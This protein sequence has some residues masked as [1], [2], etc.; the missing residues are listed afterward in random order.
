MTL[1]PGKLVTAHY[2]TGKYVGEIV[3]DRGHAYLIKILAVQ[4]HPQQGDLHNPGQTE[5]VFFHQR[6]ALS[7][8]E[9][10]NISKSSVSP[11]E[12]EVPEYKTSLL[13]SVNRLKEKLDKKDNEFNNQAKQQLE[14][15]E[16]SYLKK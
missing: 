8:Y 11:Y 7:H 15:L 16:A 14:A 2:K 12:G 5:N 1:E 10:A 13:E 3:E 9:K 6:K 4:K